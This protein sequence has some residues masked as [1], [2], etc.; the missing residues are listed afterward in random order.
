MR[1]LDLEAAIWH[2]FT[3]QGFLEAAARECEDTMEWFGTLAISRGV[4]GFGR[5]NE[6]FNKFKAFARDFRRGTELAKLGDY[7]FISIRE[8][9]DKLNPAKLK[10]LLDEKFDDLKA[11]LE[12]IWPIVPGNVREHLDELLKFVDAKRRAISAAVQTFAKPVQTVLKVIAKKLDDQAWKVETYR[13]N[14]G[15]SRRFRNRGR[16]S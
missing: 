12:K 10:A 1:H 9:G 11:L 8:A 14:R 13:T 4:P 6:I 16:R 15:G 7:K 2:L 5:N 3:S